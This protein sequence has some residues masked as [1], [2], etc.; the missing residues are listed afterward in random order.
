[1]TKLLFWVWVLVNGLAA[2]LLVSTGLFFEADE[3][4]LSGMLPVWLNAR[5]LVVSGFFAAPI[6]AVLLPG[7]VL[8]KLKPSVP[9]I[10]WV[11]GS[12]VYAVL[13]VAVVMFVSKAF[14]DWP[15]FG[16]EMFVLTHTWDGNWGD[17]L[18]LPWHVFAVQNFLLPLS[19]W[20]PAALAMWYWRGSRNMGMC[21]GLAMAV[22]T[23]VQVLSRM[24]LEVLRVMPEG[25]SFSSQGIHNL[26]WWDAPYVTGTF[27]SAC[28]G[29]AVSGLV[30]ASSSDFKTPLRQFGYAAASIILLCLAGPLAFH[31]AVGPRGFSA[32]FPEL[33]KAFTSAS[34]VELSVG[35]P[36][37]TLLAKAD[38][39][40]P[41]YLQA[42]TYALV[43]FEPSGRAFLTFDGTRNLVSVNALTGK[44]EHQVAG[45]FGR[46]DN[47][48]FTWMRD[49][50]HFLLRSGI[51]EKDDPFGVKG[52]LTSRL[53]IFVLPDY[54]LASDRLAP[55][56]CPVSTFFDPP[57][58]VQSDRAFLMRCEPYDP[59]PGMPE[60]IRVP[61]DGTGEIERIEFDAAH[62]LRRFRKLLHT[63][64]GIFVVREQSGNGKGTS[65][66]LQDV[67][68]NRGTRQLARL[69]LQSEAGALTFQGLEQQGLELKARFCGLRANVP[70]SSLHV[71]ITKQNWFCRAMFYDV[72]SLA[73][74]R[75]EEESSGGYDTYG[76]RKNT[77]RIGDLSVES[78]WDDKSKTGEITVRRFSTSHVLQHMTTVNQTII[79]V[80]PDQRLMVTHAADEA[81]LRVYRV[82][83]AAK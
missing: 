47:F 60:M 76:L 13:Y 19:L 80:S 8:R 25:H 55:T 53:R 71:P 59:K 40:P 35:K 70:T 30:L 34:L 77:R 16:S 72:A 48:S 15:H 17:V 42:P 39:Q 41:P 29:A 81:R 56:Q 26:S 9:L 62:P 82:D 6:L 83:A 45:P 2:V 43:Q 7:L 23:T 79:A 66:W 11:T 61:V 46:D 5:F 38:V 3:R 1:M 12:I 69:A 27:L 74:L 24:A 65:I 32:G 37:V 51:T 36:V 21:F 28:C 78:Q 10:I 67:D 18:T 52:R 50:K 75:Q 20:S 64:L 63:T 4:A 58:A 44:T 57:I 49:G 22:G 14:G 54:K 31:Y 73:W 33:Q 68:G